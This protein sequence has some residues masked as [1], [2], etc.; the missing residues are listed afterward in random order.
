MK[1][2]IVMTV[3]LGV[4]LA[5]GMLLAQAPGSTVQE[6]DKNL[7]HL[8]PDN[9]W[10][11]AS[12]M[13]HIFVKPW[14]DYPGF[15]FDSAGADIALEK[16]KK[17]GF[18]AVEFIQPPKTAGYVYPS[19][20]TYDNYKI[21]EELGTIEDFR[22]I[23]RI[24]HRKGM[25]VSVFF[26]L[27]Y[28][29]LQAPF[30]L[31]ACDD[32]KKGVDS[33]EVRWFLWSD[34]VNASPPDGDMIF[35]I[36]SPMT[37][38]SYGH[39]P[40][41]AKPRPRWTGL[42]MA[43]PG[44]WEHSERA[45]KYYWSKW[46]GGDGYTNSN[47][48]TG[49]HVQ[50]PHYNW[51]NVEW[52]EEAEKILTYWMDTGIEGISQ[53][54][55][56]WYIGCGWDMTRRRITSVIERYGNAYMQAEGGGV[57]Y[58]DPSV[59]ITEGGYNSV[60]DY[61]LYLSDWA[62]KKGGITLAMETGDPRYIETAL[63]NYHDRVVEAGGVLYSSAPRFEEQ[64]Q[65]QLAWATVALSG[66]LVARRGYD[67]EID[68]DLQWLLHQKR[69]HPALWQLS[70][71]RKI[72]TARDDRHYAFLRTAA[73]R[74]ERILVVLNYQPTQE[75]V[76]VDLSGVATAGLVDMKSGKEYPR[77]IPLTIDVPAYHY[78]LFIVKPAVKLP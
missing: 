55:P 63:R 67:F 12:A 31:K 41:E 48:E 29:S 39:T 57:F 11:Q 28:C 34:S 19:L 38:W 20:A 61:A 30:F 76:Q 46:G 22:R 1:K 7:R 5:A 9:W 36:T 50:M 24:A 4:L 74:S 15:P 42:K 78:R 37:V 27:G 62:G 8:I 43:K 65:Q 2:S 71:R 60:R 77:K 45:G 68:A 58:E 6:V 35:M 32:V 33:K 73:D 66:D 14:K 13:A 10:Q 17:Q 70:R 51:N 75:T 21:P 56:N 54:A 52:Q 40:E 53:D 25:A 18:S 23:V 16:L 69:D 44:I 72:P 26:N 3:L 64:Q 59:W 47:D 49:K